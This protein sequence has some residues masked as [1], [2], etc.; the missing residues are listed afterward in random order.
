MKNKDLIR[1][2]QARDPEGDAQIFVK[3]EEGGI[4]YDIAKVDGFINAPH[5]VLEGDGDIIVGA[6]PDTVIE[7]GDWVSTT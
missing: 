6:T 1:L 5:T 3:D 4:Y 2:L 7:A